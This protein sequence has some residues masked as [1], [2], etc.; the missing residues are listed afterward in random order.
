MGREGEGKARE[1]QERYEGAS[2]PF[3]SE[4]GLLGFCQVT[5]GMELRLNANS[6]N[7]TPHQK[8]PDQNE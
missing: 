7:L 4:S 2:N 3:D 8:A 6:S 5:V 1:E